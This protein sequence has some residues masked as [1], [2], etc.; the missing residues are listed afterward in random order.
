MLIKYV[1]SKF[2]SEQ[3]VKLF[4]KSVPSIIVRLS[5]IYGYTKLRRP[6]LI[7]TIMQDIF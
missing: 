7:P 4:S 5:N 3:I 6:D 1:F 2:L